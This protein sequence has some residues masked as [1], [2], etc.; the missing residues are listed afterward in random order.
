M[1]H[2]GEAYEIMLTH[3]INMLVY[4]YYVWT[5]FCVSTITDMAVVRICDVICDKFN[6][7][8][9]CITGNYIQKWI[10]K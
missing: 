10:S 6:V 9:I 7:V 4:M 2:T 1:G 8:G 3:I 5:I